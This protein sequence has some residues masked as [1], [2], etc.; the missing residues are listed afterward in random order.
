[1]L[2]IMLQAIFGGYSRFPLGLSQPEEVHRARLG[3]RPVL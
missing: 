1:M 2:Q 3:F